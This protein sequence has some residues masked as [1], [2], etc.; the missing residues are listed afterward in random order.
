[1]CCTYTDILTL[2]SCKNNHLCDAEYGA[3]GRETKLYFQCFSHMSW[4]VTT[5]A[6]HCVCVFLIVPENPSAIEKEETYT[7]FFVLSRQIYIND[8][9]RCNILL[10]KSL[11]RRGKRPNHLLRHKIRLAT[12]PESCQLF[13]FRRP[14]L[15]G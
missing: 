8:F 11:R 7:F 9:Y 14:I 5:K 2:P 4:L 12:P 3:W 15:G 13:V 10:L 6:T 1:M